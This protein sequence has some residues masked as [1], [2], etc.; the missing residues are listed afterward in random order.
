MSSFSLKVTSWALFLFFVQ[1]IV[2]A[3]Y[4]ATLYAHILFALFLF[5]IVWTVISFP[6]KGYAPRALH[7]VIWVS[8]AFFLKYWA[9]PLAWLISPP[10]YT[11]YVFSFDPDDSLLPIVM[12][13]V[14]YIS[15][16]FAAFLC[17]GLSQAP[18]MPKKYEDFMP[19][20]RVVKLLIVVY[21]LALLFK[22]YFV[23]NGWMGSLFGWG[24]VKSVPVYA[25]LI[26]P[27]LEFTVILLTVL[28]FYARRK[29]KNWPIVIVLF[30]CDVMLHVAMGDRRDVLLYLGPLLVMKYFFPQKK[31]P[32][33]KVVL[34]LF[35][36]IFVFGLVTQINQSINRYYFVADNAYII[37]FV[38][39]LQDFIANPLTGFYDAL[40]IIKAYVSTHMIDAAIHARS[41]GYEYEYNPVLLYISGFLP[42]SSSLGFSLGGLSELQMPMT[43]L[44]LSYHSDPFLTNPLPGENYIALGWFG[45]VSVSMLSGAMMMIFYHISVKSIFFWF[46]YWSLF[47]SLSMGFSGSLSGQ[48]T[49][50]IKGLWLM[51]LLGLLSS[52][53]FSWKKK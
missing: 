26:K 6:I 25:K 21:V 33:N 29:P 24:E 1:T 52:F 19:S 32:S 3:N 47:Q 43:E 51:A 12:A 30:L 41:L 36:L 45:V 20:K 50:A 27:F 49:Y 34:F 48:V 11:S 38:Y 14:S 28:S 9:G 5:I 18:V 46:W 31:I 13:A 23:Y 7:P 4:D 40:G 35:A 53:F 16:V 39:G 17:T 8:L 37:G 2:L 44:A 15:I 22:G 10:K 42:G